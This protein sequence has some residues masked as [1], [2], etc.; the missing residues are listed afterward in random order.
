MK[1]LLLLALI[2]LTLSA[3]P[4]RE[5]TTTEKM[6]SF[7]QHLVIHNRV[8]LKVKGK[9][10]TVM[11]IVKRMDMM[12]L[13]QFP[14][15]IDNEI[16]RYQFYTA[17][18]RQ[19]LEAVLDEQLIVLDA[20]ER[21]IKVSEGEVRRAMERTF[22]S[23]PITSLSK[24]GMTFSEAYDLFEADLLVQKMNMGMV[25]QR[26]LPEVKPKMILEQYQKMVA[27]NPPKEI[28]H[29]RVLSFRAPS[30]QEAK[31]KAL[32]AYTALVKG[33]VEFAKVPDLFEE[34]GITVS[35]SEEFS[36][37][38]AQ[39]SVAHRSA[40][41]ELGADTISHPVLRKGVAYL[42]QVQNIEHKEVASFH[43]MELELQ[44]SVLQEQIVA[45]TDQ[46]RKQLRERYGFGEKELAAM[47]PDDFSP[48]A[49]Q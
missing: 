14:D 5:P 19:F 3:Q 43:E 9:P 16:A 32:R 23:D 29:Y 25:Y 36:R 46:Y 6:F 35:L 26:A 44:K 41:K 31:E 40:L 18:W 4:Q 1:R 15:L 39:M 34:E 37:E 13:Q 27:E 38:T 24:I 33:E 7:D 49:L 2:P 20:E 12:F 8:V 11:D 42:F 28:Y 45:R 10:I 30:E 21:K 17:S 48:F 22:G 47:I